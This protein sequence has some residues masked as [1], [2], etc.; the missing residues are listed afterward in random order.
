MKIWP[1]T[2]RIGFCHHKCGTGYQEKVWGELC[3]RQALKFLR[4]NNGGVELDRI[5]PKTIPPRSFLFVYNGDY[6]AHVLDAGLKDYKGY[7]VVRDPRDIVVSAY[8]S[9][10][11]SHPLDNPWGREFLARH[12]DLLNRVPMEEGLMEEIR[13]AEP[14]FEQMEAWNPHDPN[15]LEVRFEAMIDRPKEIF[16]RILD[17]LGVRVWPGSLE[18][19][20]KD[21]TFERLSRGRKRG[22]E[23]IRSH[24][25]KGMPGD[26]KNY[27]TSEHTAFFNE[28]WGAFLARLGYEK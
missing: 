1:P 3:R 9:H 7:H 4:V 22:E 20:L 21:L 11:Y 8:F 25:R 2:L 16:S 14:L 26:W 27:F 24:Y 17:F 19:I 10:R 6:R 13:W 18:K 28:R 5:D 23:D 12:R 15:I